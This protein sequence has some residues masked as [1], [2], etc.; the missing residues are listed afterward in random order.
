MIAVFALTMPK[1]K[2]LQGKIDRINLVAREMLTGVP[3]IRAF[4]TE[5]YEEERFDK[6]NTDFMRTNLYVNRLMAVMMPVMML[7]MNGVM[8][9]TVYSG[10]KGIDLGKLQVGDMMAFMQYAMH[11][12]ISFVLITSIAIFM[13]RASVAAERIFAVLDS[14]T[15][16]ISPESPA[17][18]EPGQEGLLQFRDVS[19]V[20]PGAEE[21]VLDH[22]SFTA[23]KGETVAFV[24]STGSG[25]STLVNLIPRFYDVTEGSILVDG[26]DVREMDLGDLRARIG[27]VPQKAVLF[28]GTVESNMR[29]GREDAGEEEIRQA[30]DIAQAS[31]FVYEN[32]EG[33]KAPIAQGGSNVS[34]GQKQ[35]L[36]I[37][38]AIVKNPEFY[39]FDDSFSALDFK[40]DQKLRSR[41]R[42]E[43]A[44]V[45]TLIV[46]QRISTI[47][48][49]DQILVLHEGNVVGQGTH[50]E[51]M[52]SCKAYR[53]I[54]DLQLQL[55]GESA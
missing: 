49:A 33:T 21:K 5:K 38:R 9:L 20:Y 41:L 27:Y 50:D 16:I 53:Q 40:T 12:I 48:H 52:E 11:V 36:A 55:G 42:E 14:E 18:P 24:G 4:T 23:K 54:A 39:I 13:P 45:T 15:D 51:L 26:V 43:C 31:D 6:A 22:I 37:A 25:K 35:R 17:R 47:M 46:A 7:I 1:F 2:V 30:I 10:A 28:S 34:G 32:E 8:V 3:V 44:G 29:F 19:F